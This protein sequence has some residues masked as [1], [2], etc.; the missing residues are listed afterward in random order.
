M[1]MTQ[2]LPRWLRRKL[3]KP[4]PQK[5]TRPSMK[6]RQVLP[7]LPNRQQ[8]NQ[9][10]PMDDGAFAFIQAVFHVA[11]FVLHGHRARLGTKPGRKQRVVQK[12][13]PAVSPG[14]RARTLETVEQ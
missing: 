12:R 8:S 11:L 2:Y 10:G 6:E 3:A 9:G 4:V 7:T 14:L 1:T 13:N 5:V